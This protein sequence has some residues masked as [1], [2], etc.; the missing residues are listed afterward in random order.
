MNFRS[1]ADLDDTIVGNL[2][3]VPRDTRLVVGVPRSGLLAASMLALHLNL[4][5][6]DVEGLLQGRL[7]Q[8]GRRMDGTRLD[9][10]FGGPILVLDDSVSS[11]DAMLRARERL[12]SLGPE[13]NIRFAA[14]Y[15]RPESPKVVD[16]HF[17]AIRGDRIFEW[18]MMHHGH[19]L[20]RCCLDIDGV[21]CVDPSPEQNDDGPAYRTFLR[22]ARPLWI[23]TVPVAFLVT[24][25]LEKYRE[26][27]ETWLHR[28]GVQYGELRMLDLPSARARQAARA[29]ASFKAQ[30]YRSTPTELFIESNPGQAREIAQLTG[31]PVLCIE[32][33]RMVYPSPAAVHR[34][35]HKL[36]RLF[37]RRLRRKAVAA[38]QRIMGFQPPS[39]RQGRG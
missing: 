27:T 21:L 31:Q 13:V 2:H 15:V 23:P 20:G 1:I 37:F 17:E 9:G 16:I 11:G 34:S 3:K 32:T 29:H 36:P 5:L 10:V 33:R 14:V 30:V 26:P 19:V 7:I 35:A 4:P 18:N 28:H 12:S 39:G 24:S 6:T 25:R 8:S 22:E 38:Q